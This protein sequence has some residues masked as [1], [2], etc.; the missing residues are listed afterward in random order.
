MTAKSGIVVSK[1][2][3]TR[4][5]HRNGLQGCRSRRAPL[6]LKRHLQTGLKYA[7]DNLE[8]ENAYWEPALWLD[9]MKLELFGRRDVTHVTQRTLS[10]Q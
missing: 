1:K 10:T 6:L 2:T 4:A 3:I 7:E 8:K 5:L 9:E